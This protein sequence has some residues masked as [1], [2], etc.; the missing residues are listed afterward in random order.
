MTVNLAAPHGQLKVE[1]QDTSGKPLPGFTLADSI[2]VQGDGV[3]LPVHWRGR[4]GLASLSGRPVRA[5]FELT[6]GSWYGFQVV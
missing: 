1:L 5:C 4:E 3:A 2:A 6:E